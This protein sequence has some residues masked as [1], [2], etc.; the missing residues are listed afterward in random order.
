MKTVYRIIIEDIDDKSVDT[1][2]DAAGENSIEHALM[3]S[4]TLLRFIRGELTEA[5]DVRAIDAAYAAIN[6]LADVDRVE[7]N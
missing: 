6:A 4:M 7:M 2:L 5:N 3:A 1:R